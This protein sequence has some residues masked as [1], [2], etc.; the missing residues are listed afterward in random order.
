MT[1]RTSHHTAQLS[2]NRRQLLQIGGL[3]LLGISTS[4]VLALRAQSKAPV[5]RD[6]SVLLIYL[7]GGLSHIDSFDPKPNAPA[8]TNPCFSR[9][10]VFRVDESSARPIASGPIRST[11]R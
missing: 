10:A 8:D 1:T 2:S 9:E 6:K 4:S 11:N 5:K 7:P 3:G